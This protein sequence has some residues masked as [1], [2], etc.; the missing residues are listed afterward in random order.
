MRT[1]RISHCF[2]VRPLVLDF[3]DEEETS[4]LA[5]MDALCAISLFLSNV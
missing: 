5:G 1:S 3:V 2:C 4:V